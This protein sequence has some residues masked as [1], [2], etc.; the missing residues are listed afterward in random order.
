MM[1]TEEKQNQTLQELFK[2]L[3]DPEII[4]ILKRLKDI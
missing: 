4:A 1:A 3:S 2:K